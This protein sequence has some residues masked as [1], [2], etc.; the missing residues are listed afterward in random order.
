MIRRPP[1][2]TLFPYTTLFRSLDARIPVFDAQREQI[3]P[4]DDDPVGNAAPFVGPLGR[5]RR[6]AQVPAPE[7]AGLMLRHQDGHPAAP[8]HQPLKILEPARREGEAIHP[9]GVAPV[10]GLTV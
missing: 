10:G 5:I 7:E 2:S 6:G 8:L 3:P 1:R 4:I 9:V